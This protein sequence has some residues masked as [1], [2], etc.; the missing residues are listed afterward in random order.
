MTYI[1]RIGNESHVA[2]MTGSNYPRLCQN[3]LAEVR[4]DGDLFDVFEN[5]PPEEANDGCD[6]CIVED[7]I[8]NGSR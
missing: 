8:R 2:F 1:A 4:E 5:Q 7:G 3:H 6:M